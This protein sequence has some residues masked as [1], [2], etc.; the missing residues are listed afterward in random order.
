MSDPNEMTQ[1]FTAPDLRPDEADDQG[2][3]QDA[4]PPGDGIPG[5]V[6]PD[7]PAE[8]PDDAGANPAS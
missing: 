4:G 1:P 2:R 6:H 8:G 5:P 3:D 7:D